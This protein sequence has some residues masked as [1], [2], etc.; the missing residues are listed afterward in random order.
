MG[1]LVEEVGKQESRYLR[2]ECEVDVDR[3]GN[4]F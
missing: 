3:G 2:G 1:G 4:L